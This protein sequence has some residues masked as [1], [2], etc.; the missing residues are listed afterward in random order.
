MIKIQQAL[1]GYLDGHHLLQASTPLS[2]QTKKILGPLTDLS[3]T[4]SPL[5]F[6]GYLTGYPLKEEKCYAL[7]KTWYATEMSRPGCVWTHTLFISYDIIGN[8]SAAEIEMLFR[9]P[10][11]NISDLSDYSVPILLENYNDCVPAINS[12]INRTSLELLSIIVQNPSTPIIIASNSS[13]PFNQA[14]ESLIEMLGISF[15][16]DISFCTGSFSNRAINRKSLDLQIAPNAIAKLVSRSSRNDIVYVE[17]PF[18]FKNVINTENF[19]KTKEFILYCG[20]KFYRRN[21][22]VIF[23]TILS[24]IS[25]QKTFSIT[26]IISILNDKISTEDTVKIFTKIIQAI[27]LPTQYSI[28]KDLDSKIAI[29]IDLFSSNYEFSETTDIFDESTVSGIIDLLY[30]KSLE[31]VI[32]FITK[33]SRYT[34]NPIGKTAVKRISEI[35]TT[36]DLSFLLKQSKNAALWLITFN[37][38]LTLCEDVWKQDK[39]IQLEILKQLRD[40]FNN[41]NYTQVDY[42]GILYLI[43]EVSNF[44]IIS[45]LY[46]TFG[47]FSIDAFFDWCETGHDC[48][49]KSIKWVNLCKYNQILSI[50]R[51]KHINNPYLFEMV[52][53]VLDP[54]DE[55]MKEVSEETWELFYRRFCINNFSNNINTVFAQF[56]LPIIIESSSQFSKQLTKFAFVTVHSILANDEMD[57]RQ[58]DRLS[59]LLPDNSLY[60]VW[61]KCKRLRKEAKIKNLDIDFKYVD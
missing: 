57:Y 56:I 20:D 30:N 42:K 13:T 25:S 39:N 55:K 31:D 15:F 3:G 23:S 34:I 26:E 60:N 7:S 32:N 28:E 17:Y 10:I 12:S 9:R 49:Q 5:S 1:W 18:S 11:S 8:I 40:S 48:I 45:D 38:N 50:E 29:L 61:D 33:L 14:L 46:K 58:W 35:F 51:L 36:K 53:N 41:V 54:Y 21:Y 43:F 22:W 37:F 52:I 24:E 59:K 47:D 16:N 6:D 2:N 19:E 44:D 4:E 27:Y